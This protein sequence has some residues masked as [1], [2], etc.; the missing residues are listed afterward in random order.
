M[1]REREREREIE[2]ERAMTRTHLS[3]MSVHT[4]SA[5]ECG[6][7]GRMCYLLVA[8]CMTMAG[9]ILGMTILMWVSAMDGGGGEGG[10]STVSAQGP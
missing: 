1:E 7:C 9:L 10:L 5:E 4:D 3:A 2:M 6:S 8:M